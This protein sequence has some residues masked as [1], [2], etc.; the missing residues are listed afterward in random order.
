MLCHCDYFGKNYKEEGKHRDRDCCQYSGEL[1][2]SC[3]GSL[4]GCTVTRGR[5]ELRNYAYTSLTMELEDA[6]HGIHFPRAEIAAEGIRRL[7]EPSNSHRKARDMYRDGTLIKR[8]KSVLLE[9]AP[10]AGER[11][12]DKAS[13]RMRKLLESWVLALERIS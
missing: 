5:A 13:E 6:L 10:H 3:N 1:F 4:L 12:C 7:F 8:V 9:S 2:P 11:Y